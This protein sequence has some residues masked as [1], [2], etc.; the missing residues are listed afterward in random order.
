M[1]TVP[2]ESVVLVADVEEVVE[3][4]VKLLLLW[5]LLLRL[6]D[7]GIELVSS[8]VVLLVAILSEEGDPRPYI[9][10]R[11]GRILI[12]NLSLSM[13]LPRLPCVDLRRD[14]PTPL[15]LVVPPPPLPPVVMVVESN[16]TCNSHRKAVPEA[17]TDKIRTMVSSF[18]LPTTTPL[19]PFPP[20]FAVCQSLQVLG[21]TE[22]NPT[23]GS[24][25][26]VGP[27]TDFTTFPSVR[28]KKRIAPSE[29]PMASKSMERI[30]IGLDVGVV[31][32]RW[33][34]VISWIVL[35]CDCEDVLCA[36]C[37]SIIVLLMG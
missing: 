5:L 13:V 6:G 19:L 25:L 17:H 16:S 22:I 10:A 35:V 7:L 12:L 11:G 36:C 33:D 28:E 8:M 29:H 1:E 37:C 3:N 9:I 15:P 18:R 27:L 4:P 21:L 34:W 26:P 31:L 32:L 24:P 30:G 23:T 2:I 14:A 20:L